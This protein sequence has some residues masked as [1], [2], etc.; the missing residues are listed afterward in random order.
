MSDFQKLVEYEI[1]KLKYKNLS[2]EIN[3][4][5][6]FSMK[7]D[8]KDCELKYQESLKSMCIKDGSMIDV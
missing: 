7:I 5:I 2:D 4:L 3:Q 6:I 1:L 8:G